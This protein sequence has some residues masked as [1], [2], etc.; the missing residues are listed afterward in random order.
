MN[1]LIILFIL[2][3]S[4]CWGSKSDTTHPEK[5]VGS[6]IL[7]C[8]TS[9][10]VS[11]SYSGNYTVMSK[12]AYCDSGSVRLFKGS[13]VRYRDNEKGITKIEKINWGGITATTII[14]DNLLPPKRRKMK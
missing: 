9:V 5:F 8:D 3:P 12:M 10:T 7:K 6:Y 4:L 13:Y 14:V 2:I 1:K 11:N